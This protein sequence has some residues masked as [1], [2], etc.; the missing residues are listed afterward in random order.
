MEF[1]CGDVKCGARAR[2][3]LNLQF[4]IQADCYAV[5]MLIDIV[6]PCVCFT[7]H[8]FTSPFIHIE[9]KLGWSEGFALWR[10]SDFNLWKTVAR[11]LFLLLKFVASLNSIVIISFSTKKSALF[12]PLEEGYEYC[13]PD[14]HH[15]WLF[16]R[17]LLVFLCSCLLFIM[18]FMNLSVG[19]C[20]S[21]TVAI[22]ITI[23]LIKLNWT[24]EEK[25]KH[26]MIVITKY[27][28]DQR[29]GDECEEKKEEKRFQGDFIFHGNLWAIITHVSHV[30]IKRNVKRS[31][32]TFFPLRARGLSFS[33]TQAR[34]TPNRSSYLIHSLALSKSQQNLKVF[35]DGRKILQ[36]LIGRAIE[37]IERSI[38]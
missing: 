18:M 5:L 12:D 6:L 20:V 29:S 4:I 26:H 10:L 19:C 36:T 13:V 21:E 2:D 34:L 3:R 38:G 28:V 17:H 23:S 1:W 33:L 35:N 24:R 32:Q 14:W 37:L 7:T 8:P 15:E 16:A 25:W 31:S 30:M 22:V 9:M 11:L 27:T